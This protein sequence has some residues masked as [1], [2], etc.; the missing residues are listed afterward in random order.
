MTPAQRDEVLPILK[1]KVDEPID[2]AAGREVV[3]DWKLIDF[4]FSLNKVGTGR[5]F[6]QGQKMFAVARC[7]ACHK[8]GDEGKSFGINFT[9][10]AKRIKRR[11]ML[12]SM[13]SPSTVIADKYKATRFELVDGK[14]VTGLIISEDDKHLQVS[15]DPL[16]PGMLTTLS[17]SEIE[18]Q[19]ESPVSTMP[20]DL[21]N[22]L[23][24]EEVLDL[25][26]YLESGGNPE[27]EHF[28]K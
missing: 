19:A 4:V 12:V 10:V 14:V 16:N 11:D 25:L 24:Q 3:K 6:Q 23:T 9:D 8:M 15:A 22:T 20:E 26:A 18:A 2:L 21:L 1:M 5:N 13:L 7:K 28:Q 17:K 27:S